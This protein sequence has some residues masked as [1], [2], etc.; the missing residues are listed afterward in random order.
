MLAEPETVDDLSRVADLRVMGK[1]KGFGVY[2]SRF[3][4]ERIGTYLGSG[5]HG[6]G[7]IASDFGFGFSDWVLM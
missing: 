5:Q 1:S 6:T 4:S 3:D 2:A 7:R